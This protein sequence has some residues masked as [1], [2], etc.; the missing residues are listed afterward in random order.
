MELPGP[1]HHRGVQ[2]AGH[3]GRV[4]VDEQQPERRNRL[5]LALRGDG[6]DGF[7]LDR[8]PDEPICV[9]ADEDLARGGGLFQPGRDVDGV[10]R[11]EA[12]LAGSGLPARHHLA[13]VHP[14]PGGERD[15]VVALELLVQPGHRVTH[16]GG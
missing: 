2:P 8:V 3:A 7:G 13:G 15:A 6:V 16:V 5:R 11:H 4:R 9:V 10:A 14:D 12:L 1:A